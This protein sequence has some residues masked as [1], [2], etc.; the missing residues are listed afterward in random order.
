MPQQNKEGNVSVKIPGRDPSLSAI[1]VRFPLDDSENPANSKTSL[2]VLL[3]QFGSGLSC[4]VFLLGWLTS[5][6]ETFA[7][8]AAQAPSD[9]NPI[10]LQEIESF[11]KT[12]DLVELPLSAIIDVWSGVEEGNT[13]LLHGSPV[14]ADKAEGLAR[15]VNESIV[16]NVRLDYTVRMAPLLHVEGKEA[17]EVGFRLMKRYMDYV[18]T[19]FDNFD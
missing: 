5:K 2:S 19:L 1:A 3:N 11:V 9:N 6:H 14:L 8:E 13:L 17:L 12:A 15:E 4:D 16:P 10:R 18:V 7:L